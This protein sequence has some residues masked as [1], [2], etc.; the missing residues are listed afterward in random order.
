MKTSI[1]K[2]YNIL[3]IILLFSITPLHGQVTIGSTDKPENFS[4]LQ[5]DGNNGGL[6]LPRLS[7]TERDN[8]GVDDTSAGLLIFND[9]SKSIEYW[10]G[11]KWSMIGDTIRI[12]NGIYKDNS[13]KLV[14]LGGKLELPTEI[15]LN[16]NKLELFTGDANSH[17]FSVN[18]TVY[19]VNGRVV[20]SK[21]DAFNVNRNTLKVKENGSSVTVANTLKVKVKDDNLRV[22][23]DSVYLHGQLS[24]NTGKANINNKVLISKLTGDAFW[25]SLK[26][27]IEIG[28]TFLKGNIKRAGTGNNTVWVRNN[29]LG[30]GS[31]DSPKRYD[32]SISDTLTLTPGK[33]MIFS[34][35]AT[36]T[37]YTAQQMFTWSHLF[38]PG[39][40]DPTATIGADV[41]DDTKTSS[42]QLA[43][44]MDVKSNT[45]IFIKAGTSNDKSWL[46]EE[47]G[48]LKFG[49]P[50]F[51]ALMI[52]DYS[53]GD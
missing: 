53:E 43:Y 39:Q 35:F 47:Y 29:S 19:V 24:I 42:P 34:K 14:K 46:I 48:D 15:N 1:Y 5:I 25:G 41:E 6:R 21:P 2:L 3:W 7:E 28:K 17:G 36:R 38:I 33:W 22:S 4:A 32:P 8:L 31:N 40:T 18:D 11:V 13:D 49:E 30:I 23:N 27:D 51:F 10:D 50:Y 45:K 26:P 37:D 9:T 12:Y 44:L 20:G 16:S 52:E